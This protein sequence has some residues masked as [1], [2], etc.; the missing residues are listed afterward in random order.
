[1]GKKSNCQYYPAMNSVTYNKVMSGGHGVSGTN[2]ISEI[3]FN[4]NSIRSNLTLLM[5]QI[6]E[7]I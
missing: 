2:A 4:A 3:S 7:T 1:M 6:F 5:T